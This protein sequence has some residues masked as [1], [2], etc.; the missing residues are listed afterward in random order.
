MPN[1]TQSFIETLRNQSEVPHVL[2]LACPNK[3]IA[4]HSTNE[5]LENGF[6]MFAR[7]NP[8]WQVRVYD[9]EDIN[10]FVTSSSLIDARDKALLNDRKKVP[11]IEVVDLWRLMVMYEQGGLYMDMDRLYNIPIERILTP[12]T[13]MILPICLGRDFCQDLMAGSPGNP[14]FLRAIQLN[15]ERRRTLTGSRRHR[16]EDILWLG[17][18]TYLHATEVIFGER[19]MPDLRGPSYY[20]SAATAKPFFDQA[21]QLRP[22]VATFYEKSCSNTLIYKGQQCFTKG[23]ATYYRHLGIPHAWGR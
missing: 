23:K 15:V 6:R 17:P 22:L 21:M 18:A 14:V 9:D 3:T 1:A 19:P 10:N 16:N 2:H 5:M 13:R 7:M 12:A 20:A 4:W 8:S 11:Y